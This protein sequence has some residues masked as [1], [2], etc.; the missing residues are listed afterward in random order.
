[1]KAFLS[2][3]FTH[4]IPTVFRIFIRDLCTLARRPVA[5]IIA[6][7]VAF[8]PSLYAWVNIYANWDPYGNTSQ[9]QVAVTSNDEGY[10][11]EGMS[12]N[13]G[14]SILQNLRGN[15]QI[16]WQF[17]DEETAISGVRSGEYYAAVV[18]PR[19]F[20]E[21]V[22]TFID[23]GIHRPSIVY[24]SNEKKNA[25][26]TKITSTGVS[27]LRTTINEQ[28]VSTVSSTLLDVLQLTDNAMEEHGAA[29]TGDITSSLRRV[30]DSLGDL[31]ISVDLLI[32]TANAALEL[33]DAAQAL[34]PDLDGVVGDNLIALSHL[35]QLAENASGVGSALSGT[36]DA[37]MSAILS[38]GESILD[39]LELVT[40]DVSAIT[41]DAADALD[42]A[43][44]MA[45]G[46]ADRVR[47]ARDFFVENEGKFLAMA[48]RV[49]DV[50]ANLGALGIPLPERPAG[51]LQSRLQRG[52]DGLIVSLGQ[53]RS[54]LRAISRDASNA[55]DILR[56]DGAL[57]AGAAAVLREDLS[58]FREDLKTVK[59]Q[60]QSDVS[61]L[62]DDT[63][64]QFY[65]CI[66]S[67]SGLLLTTNQNLPAV[68]SVLGSVDGSLSHSIAALESTK[69]LIVNA[70]ENIDRMLAD[71]DSVERSEK[72]G[73]LMTIIREDPN[74]VAEFLS[75]PVEV[76]TEKVYPVENYGSAMTPF[77]SILAIWVGG[78]VLCA[79]FK[80]NVR[81]DEK[82]HDLGPTVCYFGRYCLF[83]LVALLQALIICLGDLYLLH[84]QCLHP[85]RFILAGIVSGL[86][87]SLL[88]YTLTI[89]FKD[90]GKAIA[91]IVMIVQVA[92]AGGTFPVEV[93]PPVF[94]AVNPYLPFTYSINAM[95]ECIAGMYANA[96][97]CDLLYLCAIYIPL[98]L[99][100]GVV[101]RRPVIWL[102]NFFEHQV[103]KTG[104]M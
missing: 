97:A 54:D 37:N 91:V 28:F 73:R 82:L 78:L 16:G 25:I 75:S 89:S 59:E 53:L 1:M 10:T 42:R 30:R 57:P 19:T 12:L 58:R 48:K 96:Y 64:S 46:A 4:D 90:V 83:A 80:T 66:D 24:Y 69:A 61:P 41:G 55:A 47:Q 43:A 67:L 34:L 68:G 74:M 81:E 99:L 76:T 63:F 103:E 49:D 102:M 29:I 20:S 92:G 44:V 8:L 62:L 86:V 94:Q 26:A 36:L 100:I 13:L 7:G 31:L 17:V 9:L 56:A 40:G 98:S 6:L 11:I 22:A 5:L 88:I 3:L 15:E 77:Y 2:K 18:I 27:T 65:T 87:Y 104:L 33:T 39:D 60:Y 45:D 38:S 85:A 93:M 23:T 71:L 14:E 72:F 84:I 50:Y 21:D 51:S 52:I 35:R 32:D 101:L 70:Q 95:R 79:I